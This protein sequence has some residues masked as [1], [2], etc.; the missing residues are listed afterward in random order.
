MRMINGENVRMQ[1]QSYKLDKKWLKRYYKSSKAGDTSSVCIG[2]SSDRCEAHF[3]AD[4][5]TALSTI[6][7]LSACSR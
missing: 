3:S 4:S 6:T 5:R 2:A 7:Y 1:L